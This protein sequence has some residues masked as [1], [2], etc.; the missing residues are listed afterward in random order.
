MSDQFCNTS[1]RIM[2]WGNKN[3]IIIKEKKLFPALNLEATGVWIRVVSTGTSC[4]TCTS[5]LVFCLLALSVP[6]SLV[7]GL[8]ESFT[9]DY[10]EELSLSVIKYC[11][12]LYSWKCSL[13]GRPRKGRKR[14]LLIA[15]AKG[16]RY[17]ECEIS[18]FH[19]VLFIIQ[20]TV[21]RMGERIICQMMSKERI[22]SVYV[23]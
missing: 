16:A 2:A 1:D 17:W 3:P 11:Q 22:P 13:R 5:S 19:I 6:E 18:T 23:N 9:C 20:R 15:S 4:L 10:Q 21:K 8:S 12:L 7:S 14:V